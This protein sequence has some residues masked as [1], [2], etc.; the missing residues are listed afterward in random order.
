MKESLTLAKYIFETNYEN[1][2]RNVA[3]VTKKSLLDGIGVTLGAGTLGEGCRAFVDLAIQGGGKKESTIIGFNTKVPSYM[4]AFANGSMAHA[5]DF[6]DAHEGALV[7]SNAA[8][9]PAAL[10]VAESREITSGK[11]L[12]T[13]ITLGSDIVCRMGLSL[14]RRPY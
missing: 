7:H 1:L 13:A 3:E 5:L 8:T 2:P 14:E 11:E 9:I 4:A 12:I 10:A 6:E